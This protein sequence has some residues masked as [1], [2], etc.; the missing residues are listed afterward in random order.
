MVYQA[1]NWPP[2]TALYTINTCE[3]HPV[4]Y[5]HVSAVLLLQPNIT[6]ASL[7]QCAETLPVAT[8]DISECTTVQKHK[9]MSLW[10]SLLKGSCHDVKNN[11]ERICKNFMMKHEFL[12]TNIS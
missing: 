7:N 3:C 6:S 5:T 4:P 12:I 9:L 10:F 11:T 8:G 2:R 1:Y